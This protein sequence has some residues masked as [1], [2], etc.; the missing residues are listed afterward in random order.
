MN[1]TD[2]LIPDLPSEPPVDGLDLVIEALDHVIPVFNDRR[3]DLGVN[4]R[5]CWGLARALSSRAQEIPL[6]T[7]NNRRKEII[8]AAPKL[9]ILKQMAIKA[10]GEIESLRQQE[11]ATENENANGRR[12]LV[13][14][15]QGHI[16][17]L[18]NA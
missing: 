18:Q 12:F 7:Q 6:T 1:A 4:T 17:E 13:G 10:G 11:W 14:V 9:S 8:P 15:A 16:R 3:L 2:R 5:Y